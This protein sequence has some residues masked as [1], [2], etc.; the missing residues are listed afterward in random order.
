[1][2][3]LDLAEVVTQ[4]ALPEVT[5]HPQRVL[6]VWVAEKGKNI[7]VTGHYTVTVE[8]TSDRQTFSQAPASMNLPLRRWMV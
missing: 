8:V 5:R 7:V 4:L 1:M 2:E 6:W 3:I